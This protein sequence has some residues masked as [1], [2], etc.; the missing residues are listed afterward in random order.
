MHNGSLAIVVVAE[1]VPGPRPDSIW[2]SDFR[3]VLRFE[4][5][6]AMRVDQVTIKLDT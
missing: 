1:Q 4:I 2:G 6:K 5:H 3:V